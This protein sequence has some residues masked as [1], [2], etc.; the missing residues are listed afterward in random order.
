MGRGASINLVNNDLLTCDWK[1]FKKTIKL[2]WQTAKREVAN[3]GG[4]L[5][6]FLRT[7]NLKIGTGLG[8]VQAHRMA[9]CLTNAYEEYSQPEGSLPLAL[10]SNASY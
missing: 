4:I 3:V 1:D 9:H 6:L 2:S 10:E 7:S 8:I 5:P